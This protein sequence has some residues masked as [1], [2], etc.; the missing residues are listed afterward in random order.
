MLIIGLTGGIGSGKSSAAA[1]FARRGASVMHADLI[2]RE[3]LE[4]DPA[5]RRLVVR[6]FGKN[7]YR[8]DGSADRPL[9]AARVFG[10]PKA[11]R[12]LNAIL[13][14]RVRKETIRRIGLL[15]RTAGLVVIEAALLYEARWESLCDYT[16]VVVAPR[17]ER[18]RRVR[19]RDRCSRQDVLRRMK[20]QMPQREQVKRGDVVIRNTGSRSHFKSRCNDI[21]DLFGLISP[22]RRRTA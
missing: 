10:D 22:A 17:E 15:P 19:E 11:L 4:T 2:A 8:A 6:A 9:I 21:Y 7:S 18:I 20:R 13:H 5:I 1:T 12:R 14:P 3:L 16:V